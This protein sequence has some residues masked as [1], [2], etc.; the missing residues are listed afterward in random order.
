M[1]IKVMEIKGIHIISVITF[2][3]CA[4]HFNTPLTPGGVGMQYI[5]PSSYFLSFST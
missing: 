5:E 2:F 4:L 3:K 1:I